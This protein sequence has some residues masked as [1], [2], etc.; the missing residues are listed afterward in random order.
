MAIVAKRR[1]KYVLDFYDQAGKRRWLTLPVG[2]TKKEAK[3]SLA[4]IEKQIKHGTYM[5]IR[6]VPAFSS[7]AD[8]WLTS[9]KSS[10]RESTH[11][12]YKGHVENHLKPFLSEMKVTQVTFDILEKFKTDALDKAVTPETLKKIFVTLSA[13]LDYAVRVRCI[14][15]NPSIY[16]ERPTNGST[17]DH[18][19]TGQMSILKPHQIRALLDAA[20]TGRDRT[21]FMTAVLTGM[22]EGELL[23]LKWGDIDWANCQIQ[24]RG[25]YNHGKFYEPKTNTSKRRIDLAPELVHELKKW[26][27]A[28]PKGDLNLVFPSTTGTPDSADNMLKRRFF[29]LLEKAGL[30]RIRFHDL[31]HTY[32]SLL[33]D[34]NENPKYI[35]VQMGHS[36]IKVTM[37]IYGHLMNDVNREAA[38]KLGRCV[39]GG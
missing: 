32:A 22:R 7:I 36:S 4:E 18:D 3:E 23:G 20:D 2:T 27:L 31:R 21:L 25:T 34:Q 29:P 17:H 9:K 8:T 24:V 19:G 11:Q 15:Y 33:I 14:E 1:G 38:C 26:N 35:Q 37:D 13:I 39:L 30:H 10:I 16:V 5:P 12:Q 28:C 6:V